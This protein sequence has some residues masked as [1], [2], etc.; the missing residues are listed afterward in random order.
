MTDIRPEL[1]CQPET[2]IYYARKWI[3]TSPMLCT[4]ENEQ[5][6]EKRVVS[7]KKETT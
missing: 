2:C 7:D 4:P 1:V 3:Q 6:K 5:N